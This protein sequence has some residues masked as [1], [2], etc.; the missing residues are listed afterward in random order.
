MRG[1]GLAE[2]NV[3]RD[4]AIY[5]PYISVPYDA[6]LVR[7]LLYWDKVCSV[8]PEDHLQDPGRLEPVMRDLVSAVLVEQLVPVKYAGEIEGLVEP[9][10]AYVK[11]DSRRARAKNLLSERP[12]HEVCRSATRLTRMR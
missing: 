9:F 5:F 11:K 2:T 8:V 4:N 7:I 1:G 12:A 3:V 6:W 10:H